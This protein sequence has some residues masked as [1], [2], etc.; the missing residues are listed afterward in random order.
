MQKAAS[1]AIRIPTKTYLRKY[2]TAK[3]SLDLTYNSTL[4][5]IILCLLD[6]KSH[7]INMN[8]KA[9]ESRLQY[10]NDRITFT[11]SI[12]TLFYKGLV[13]TTDKIIAINRYMENAFLEDLHHWCTKDLPGKAIIDRGWIR[14]IDLSIESFAKNYGIELDVDISYDALKKAEYRYRKRLQEKTKNF[15]PPINGIQSMYSLAS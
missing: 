12:N 15:V 9:M 3:N 1:Y 10:M 2:I 7:N 6:K 8:E 14:G 5:T 11:T 4:G 13:L